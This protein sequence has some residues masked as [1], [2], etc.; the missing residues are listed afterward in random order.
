MVRLLAVAVM[1]GIFSVPAAV[2]AQTDFEQALGGLRRQVLETRK[3]QDRASLAGIGEEI[4]RAAASAAELRASAEA[5]RV[6]VADIDRR[7]RVPRDH[8]F[9]ADLR[10]LVAD[11]ESFGQGMRW[12]SEDVRHLERVA[13]VDPSLV[14][15]AQALDEN[16][17]Q[18]AFSCRGLENE[19]HAIRLVLARAGYAQE[20]WDLQQ[21]GLQAARSVWDILHS[22]DLL[23]D[24][25][26]GGSGA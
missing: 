14:Q 13:R 1:A 20:G 26:R 15:P 9:E 6:R 22:A 12:L 23:V 11:M 7:A 25:V 24:K 3:E 5:L 4:N 2:Q 10:R 8:R 18:L 16:A 17:R 21:L 19:T